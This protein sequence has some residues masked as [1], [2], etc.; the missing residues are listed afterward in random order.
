MIS[1]RITQKTFNG[2]PVL[3]Q[4]AL[5]VAPGETVA[6][7]GPSGMGKTTLL[8]ILA[9][10]DTRFEGQVQ[11]PERLSYVFQEPNLLPW[12]TALDNITL[13]TGATPDAAR[14]AMEDVGLA[15]YE[16]RFPNQMSLGQQR[17]LSLARAF[18]AR[19]QVLLMDEPFVSLD[20][21]RVEELLSLTE[22]MLAGAGV[23]TVMVTHT[24]AEADRLADRILRLGGY[25]AVLSAV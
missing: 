22:R 23:A 1:A 5:D 3:G 10:L 24:V 18:A 21:D 8:R 11:R 17:R 14:K 25:P 6:V 2:E 12:R 4:I 19:P 9:G 13:V 15:G 20:A 16:T 7:T